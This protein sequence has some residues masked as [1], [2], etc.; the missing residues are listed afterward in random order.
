MTN[1]SHHHGNHSEHDHGAMLEH[2][3][4]VRL[5]NQTV[6]GIVVSLVVMF[7]SFSES[8]GLFG[9]LSPAIK[10]YLLLALALPVQVLLGWRFY[11]SSWAAVRRFSANMDT[12]IA[13]GSTTAFLLSAAVTI[14]P[15]AFSG[16]PVEVYF[17]S[18]VVILTLIVLGKYLEELGKRRSEAA[19][20]ALLR[21]QPQ[22]ARLIDDRGERDILVGQIKVNDRLRVRPGEKVPIDGVILEGASSLDESMVTGE[23]VPKARGPGDSVIGGALNQRGSFVMRAER[24]GEQTFLSSI[25]RQVRQA[26]A[27][28]AP[29]QDLADEISAYFVPIVVILAVIAGLAWYYLGPAP[30]LPW[31]VSIFSSV[32]IIACPCALGLATPTAV[33]VGMGRGATAGILIHDAKAL[34]RAAA[35]NYV[36]FDK[37]GTL[38]VGHPEVTDVVPNPFTAYTEKLILQITASVEQFSEHAL[39]GSVV[40]AAKSR[41]LALLAVSNFSA[42]AGRGITATLQGKQVHLGSLR[43]LQEQTIEVPALKERAEKFAKAGKTLMYLAVEGEFA[44]IIAVADIVKR[45]AKD[46]V[47][48]LHRLGISVAMLTGDD[49]RTAKAVAG[50]LGIERVLSQVLPQDKA[51]EVRKLQREHRVV[52]FVGDGINDAPAL[53][54]ADVGIAMGAGT[55]VALETASM[56]VMNSSPDGVLR[57][58]RLAQKTMGIIRGNLFWAFAYNV[59]AIP[60]AAGVFYPFFGWLLSP[61]I[62]A[63]AMAFS[64]LAVVLNSL[65]LKGVKI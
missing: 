30:Q 4:V 58:M 55:G 7:L 17:D 28:R 5:R 61:T 16:M 42:H 39:A 31:A 19:I 23:S 8:A 9:P 44:G 60:I 54:A 6:F 47:K 11:K 3:E 21:L 10:N 48:S 22:T 53:A 13:L 34:E 18:A 38:T 40:T 57:G 41:G 45:Q 24:T 35:I 43:F 59:I 26:Q 2:R 62:S 46:T 51:A 37:T 36:I 56:A 33:A 49:A 27:S 29:I 50:S 63:G 25:I 12:L 14:F 52:A 32:L 1:H 15:Q 20:E 64:S 65:R